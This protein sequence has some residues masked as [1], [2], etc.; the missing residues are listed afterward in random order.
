MSADQPGSTYAADAG[1]GPVV[2]PPPASQLSSVHPLHTAFTLVQP[3]ASQALP[4]FNVPVGPLG[5]QTDAGHSQG[6]PR[7]HVELD[8]VGGRDSGERGCGGG[9]HTQA[10]ALQ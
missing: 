4:S 9:G 5:L 7:D 3:P 1:L 6:R 8:Q 10:H 2:P